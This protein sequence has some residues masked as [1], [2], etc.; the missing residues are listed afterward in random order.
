[1]EQKEAF[2]KY[3]LQKRKE[4]GLS[5]REL[6]QRLFV[7]ESAV[8]KWERGLSYPDITLVSSLCSVLNISEH[9]LMTASDDLHQR[10]IEEQARRYLRIMKTYSW[11][12]WLC[13]A[14]ALIPLFLWGLITGNGLS[15]FWI[16]LAALTMVFSVINVP[17]LVKDHRPRTCFW[18]FYGST[19]LLLVICRLVHVDADYQHWLVMS[20]LGVSL[21]ALGIFLPMLLP[22]YEPVHPILH[23]KGLICIGADTL[24]I[25]LLVLFGNH[26]AGTLTSENLAVFLPLGLIYT[27]A[28]WGIFFVFR[29]AA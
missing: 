19:I 1:M 24:L 14:V 29:Y 28:A 26:F 18:C 22:T 16:T 9:E 13:Y 6:A 7:S 27:C 17:V 23:H 20:V 15:S 4:A 5:Q 3:I 2:G 11:L 21:A 10:E 12:T 25:W 8:S